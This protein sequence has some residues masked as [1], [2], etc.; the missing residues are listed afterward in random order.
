MGTDC[1]PLVVGLSLF[2][3]ERDFLMINRQILLMLLILNPD[4]R[5]VF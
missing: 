4:F 2:C 5:M 3:Y 1:A